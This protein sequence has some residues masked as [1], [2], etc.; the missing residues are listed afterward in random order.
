MRGKVSARLGTRVRVSTEEFPVGEGSEV[1]C[2]PSYVGARMNTS[3]SLVPYARHAMD[4]FT[5]ASRTPIRSGFM[6]DVDAEEDLVALRR[7]VWTL[8]KEDFGADRRKC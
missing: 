3:G 2:L 8:L 5:N 6:A 1:T 7:V 4:A